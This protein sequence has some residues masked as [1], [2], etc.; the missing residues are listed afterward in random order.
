M[1]GRRH[2]PAIRMADFMNTPAAPASLGAAD[3]LMPVCYAGI[4]LVPVFI[5]MKNISIIIAVGKAPTETH[6]FMYYSY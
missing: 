4:L 1:A 5:R 3:L 2:K 6:W